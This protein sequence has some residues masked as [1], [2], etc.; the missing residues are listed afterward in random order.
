M[1]TKHEKQ[2]QRLSRIE[3]QVRGIRKMIEEGRYCIEIANQIKAARSALKEV[4][5][6]VLDAH[7]RTCVTTAIQSRKKDR[8]EEKLGEVMSLLRSS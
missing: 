8:I 4:G 3:G 5:L 1:T 2:L 7:L 6:T